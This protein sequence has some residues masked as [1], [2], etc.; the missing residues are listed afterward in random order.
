MQAIYYTSKERS[1]SQLYDPNSTISSNHMAHA[2][3]PTEMFKQSDY[4]MRALKKARLKP[5]HANADT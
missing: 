3:V 2:V 5:R 4:N 1:L